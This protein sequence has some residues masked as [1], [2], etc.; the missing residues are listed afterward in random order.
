MKFFKNKIVY[1]SLFWIINFVFLFIL[2]YTYE[3]PENPIYSKVIKI[4]VFLLLV[5]TCAVYV[6]LYFLIPKFFKTKQYLIY[7]LLLFITIIS[8]SLIK[9]YFTLKMK[10]EIDYNILEETFGFSVILIFYIGFTLFFKFF[11]EWIELKN[12]ELKMEKLEKQ[13]IYSELALLKSQVNPHFL[14]N[15]LNN[16]YALSLVKSDSASTLVMKLSE[17]MRYMLESSKQK[18]VILSDEI[19]YIES[20]IELE[21]VR[22][23][24]KTDVQLL[25]S[26]ELN[27]YKIAPMVLI[28]FIENI[29]KH[30]VNAYAKKLYAKIDLKI[31]DNELNFLVENSIPENPD[32]KQESTKTGL[33]NIKKRLEL[34]YP[35]NHSLKINQSKDLYQIEL[36]VNLKYEDKM[37]NR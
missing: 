18:F 32:V 5:F 30:G 35:D 7:S 21:K 9:Y 19:N 6:N 29:F 14:F 27:N 13:N 23:S 36:K 37:F 31:I 1:H 34:I 33:S 25:K 3:S 11:K 24:I 10:P 4:C 17:L 2:I 26:G 28:P 20:Y 8:L 12:I 16:I 22:V 15:T